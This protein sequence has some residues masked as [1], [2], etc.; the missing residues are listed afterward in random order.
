MRQGAGWGDRRGG[1]GRQEENQEQSLSSKEGAVYCVER[2]WEVMEGKETALTSLWGLR[3]FPEQLF[4]EH[5]LRARCC[6]KALRMQ[7]PHRAYIP[8]G[9]GARRGH[10]VETVRM[11]AE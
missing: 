6:S 8:T 10:W 7:C 4:F 11:Q 2:E 9:A 1:Q 5:L 3:P